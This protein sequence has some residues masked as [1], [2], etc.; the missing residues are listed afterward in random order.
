MIAVKI[1]RLL[2]FVPFTAFCKPEEKLN[3]R[4]KEEPLREGALY[5]IWRSCL[6]LV[7]VGTHI[8]IGDAVG[9]TVNEPRLSGQ[10]DFRK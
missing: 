7:L 4:I 9:V 3:G 8:H 10:V 1:E 2:L 5:M 6:W